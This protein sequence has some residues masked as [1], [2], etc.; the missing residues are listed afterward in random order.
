MIDTSVLCQNSLPVKAECFLR[1]PSARHGG[2]RRRASDNIPSSRRALKRGLRKRKRRKSPSLR[3]SLKQTPREAAYIGR[4]DHARSIYVRF[5]LRD[6]SAT[7][8]LCVTLLQPFNVPWRHAVS[9]GIH[10][11]RWSSQSSGNAIV[12]LLWPLQCVGGFIATRRDTIRLSFGWREV[13]I[14][15]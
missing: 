7:L 10:T 6:R 12:A 8:R 1:G 9:W 3:P 4:T 2:R 14:S 15:L 13:T 11:A 5:R